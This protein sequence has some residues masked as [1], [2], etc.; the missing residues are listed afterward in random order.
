MSL[1]PNPQPNL[2]P[3]PVPGPAPMAYMTGAEI[4]A[5]LAAR[6][7]MYWSATLQ[8]GD[9]DA[10]IASMAI[11]EEA[12]FIGV[13][14]NPEQDRQWP[15][16]FKYGWPNIVASP[17][18]L[19]V[20]RAY[21]GAWYLDYEGVVPQQILDCVALEAYRLV[22]LEQTKVVTQESVSGA[23][24]K[25]APPADYPHGQMSQ[26]DRRQAALLGPFL[27]RDGHVVPFINWEEF[28]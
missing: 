27:Q 7:P 11:D 18:P 24:V 28:G 20:S 15:R 21:A 26:L 9:G 1:A 2:G 3:Y 13:K 4:T 19:L 8:I 6:Y 16:T 14:V 10:L 12:P 22:T 17:S 23:T 5:L 25:Y